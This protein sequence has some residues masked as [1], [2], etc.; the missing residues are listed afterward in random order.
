MSYQRHLI[1]SEKLKFALMNI[2]LSTKILFHNE[3][4]NWLNQRLEL[5]A[6]GVTPVFLL[7]DT[8]TYQL[9]Y[10]KIKSFFEGFGDQMHIIVL[11]AGE[12][13]KSLD[14]CLRIWKELL[15]AEAGRDAILFN[16]GGGMVTDLGGFAAS[17]FKRGIRTIHIPT[18]L[19]GMV[20]AAIGHKTAIDFMG[21]KNPIGSFYAAEAVLIMTDFL[22]TLPKNQL[23]SGLAEV[24]KYGYIG[25]PDLINLAHI[26]KMNPKHSETIIR[27]CIDAKQHIVSADPNELGL[28]KILNFGHTIGHAVEALAMERNDMLLHGEAVAIGM[29]CALWIS[30]EYFQTATG[31]LKNYS[32]W[33]RAHF[34]QFLIKPADTA[35]LL[36]LMRQDKKNKGKNL[37]FVLIE[38]VGKP[39]FDVGVPDEMV[40]ESLLIYM[41]QVKQ[42]NQQKDN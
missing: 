2:N 11:D 42:Y 17:V 22:T 5:L 3:A 32:G 8:N 25:N 20:D 19:L 24:I 14:S 6:D 16:L 31:L 27:Y 29:F 10:P 36:D 9:C 41:Q 28:R 26:E 1:S 12:A 23:V 37:R 7:A 21:V 30:E 18:T 4:T 34:K 39:R 38:D 35:R 13:S 40:K 33:Y 15:R